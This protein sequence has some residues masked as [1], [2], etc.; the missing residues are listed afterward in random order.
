MTVEL[1]CSIFNDISHQKL[2]SVVSMLQDYKA[3]LIKSESAVIIATLE[4]RHVFRVKLGELGILMQQESIME[5]DDYTMAN[6]TFLIGEMRMI[7]ENSL[8]ELISL[9]NA[10]RLA[11]PF[12]GLRLS[13]FQDA[14]EIPIFQHSPTFVKSPEDIIQMHY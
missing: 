8:T 6:K 1:A 11:M 13:L 5:L 7:P 14:E 9:L 3:T 2:E 12:L 10:M 4:A